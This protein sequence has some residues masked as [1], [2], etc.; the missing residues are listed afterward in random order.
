MQ[1]PLFL[2]LGSKGVEI[3]GVLKSRRRD[4]ANGTEGGSLG[5][6]LLD[7]G[8]VSLQGRNQSQRAKALVGA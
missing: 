3:G 2:P 1:G 6:D 8:K 4:L 7:T 5:V